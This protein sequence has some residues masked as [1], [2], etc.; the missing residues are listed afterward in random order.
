MSLLIVPLVIVAATAVLSYFESERENNRRADALLEAENRLAQ[1]QQQIEDDRVQETVLQ[2]YIQDMADLLLHEGLAKPS[3]DSSV[4]Q[5]AQA[6]TLI[7]IRQLDIYVSW[8]SIVKEYCCN[9]YMDRI[10]LVPLKK[11]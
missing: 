5:I 8:T 11:S 1:A 9:S 6:S 10:S 4:R 7:A 2:S 3:P